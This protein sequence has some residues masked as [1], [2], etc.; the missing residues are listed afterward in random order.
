M[1]LPVEPVA[2]I[3][4]SRLALGTLLDEQGPELR[5][6]RNFS[7]G[8]SGTQVDDTAKKIDL[9]QVEPENFPFAHPGKES[10]RELQAHVI[11]EFGEEFFVLCNGSHCFPPRVSAFSPAAFSDSFPV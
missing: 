8:F 11:R 3:W 9:A 10:N 5:H 4:A 2:D 6:D 7:L 1:V